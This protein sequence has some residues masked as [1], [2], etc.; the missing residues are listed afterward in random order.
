M[1]DTCSKMELAVLWVIAL[2]LAVVLAGCG[3]SSGPAAP[4]PEAGVQA[5]SAP[6]YF[7][8]DLTTGE[9]I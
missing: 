1:F 2:S 4:S 7:L 3:G 5:T 9:V 6:F 8:A